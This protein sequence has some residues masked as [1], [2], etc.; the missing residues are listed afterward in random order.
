VIEDIGLKQDI[1][2]A[3][4]KGARVYRKENGE[5][6]DGVRASDRRAHQARQPVAGFPH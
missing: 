1:T 3:V 2:D 6:P 4:L 5:L